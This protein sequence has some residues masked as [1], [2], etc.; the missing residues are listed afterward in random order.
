MRHSLY[1][2]SKDLIVLVFMQVYLKK[3]R[4]FFK[5]PLLEVNLKYGAGCTVQNSISAVRDR[6]VV[7]RNS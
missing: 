2:R 1:L 4:I 6:G 5:Y 3:I 7:C